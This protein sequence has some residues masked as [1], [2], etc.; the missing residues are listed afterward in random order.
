MH[1]SRDFAME[2]SLDYIF[3]QK[4]VHLF[5]CLN[6]DLMDGH[7][8]FQGA[9]SFPFFEELLEEFQVACI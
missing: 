2:E 3:K 9:I 8:E 4:L 1:T 6:T 5:I 7:Q